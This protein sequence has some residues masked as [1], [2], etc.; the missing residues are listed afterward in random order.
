MMTARITAAVIVT[1]RTAMIS[2]IPVTSMICRQESW[3]TH[4]RSPR[5]LKIREEKKKKR[6]REIIRREKGMQGSAWISAHPAMPQAA[7][8]SG[9]YNRPHDRTTIV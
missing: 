3:L 8:L 6:M 9:S 4:Q 1:V 7:R 2:M 5:R